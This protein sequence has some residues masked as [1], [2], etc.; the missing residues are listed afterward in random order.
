MPE[1]F[2]VFCVKYIFLDISELETF[3][4][5]E[6]TREQIVICEADTDCSSQ[7]I[8]ILFLCLKVIYKTALMGQSM[9]FEAHLILHFM[10]KGNL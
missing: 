2:A 6:L 5:T 4:F 9:L 7:S 1:M 10:F 3:L 8:Q